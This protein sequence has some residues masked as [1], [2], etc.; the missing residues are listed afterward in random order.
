MAR[1]SSIPIAPGLRFGQLTVIEQAGST[2]SG[3]FRWKCRCD[4]GGI[5]YPHATHLRRGV[6]QSCGCR[7]KEI[8]S[9]HN[10]KDITNQRFGRL[11]A[12]YRTGKR[13]SKGVIWRVRCDCNC[14]F[15]AATGYLGSIKSCGCLQREKAAQAN[16]RHGGTVGNK[17]SP[18]YVCWHDIKRR[19]FDPKFTRA[20]NY[21]ERGISLAPEW[22][23]DFAAFRDYVNQN[24]GPRPKGHSIDRIENSEGYFPGNLRWATPSQQRHN[25]RRSRIGKAVDAVL[26]EEL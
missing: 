22:V 23:N 19:C 25:S 15:E 10:A 24:L 2:S 6:T 20:K 9:K 1:P 8:A 21:S 17:R 18:L 13:C 4:C 5:S 12:L 14:E 16:Y 3:G 11:V 7:Q 26:L